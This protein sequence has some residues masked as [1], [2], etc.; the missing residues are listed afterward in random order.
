MLFPARAGR[1]RLWHGYRQRP[2]L[3]R[4][5]HRPRSGRRARCRQPRRARPARPRRRPQARRRRV[6]VLGLHP[7]EDDDPCGGRPR[8]GPPR[9]RARRLGRSGHARLVGRRQAHPRGGHRQLGRPGRGRPAHRQ[10]A[11]RSCAAPGRIAGPGRVDV[12][13]TAYTATKGIV[14]NTGTT[15]AVPPIE[16]LRDTPYWTN[17][18]VI[19]TTELPASL[20][21]LGGGAIGCR[22]EPGHGPLRRRRDDRRGRRPHPRARGAGGVCRAAAGSRGRRHHG[23]AGRRRRQGHPRRAGVHGHAGRRLDR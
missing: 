3:R 9:R 15:A 22:A 20:V 2:H 5:R 14:V 19:E 4:H 13:G 12:D 17:H 1:V 6:P 16:G 21:V 7:V 11:R 8:R 10:R 23:A 18:E